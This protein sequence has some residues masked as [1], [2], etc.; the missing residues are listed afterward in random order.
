MTLRGTVGSLVESHRARATAPDHGNFIPKFRLPSWHAQWRGVR[1]DAQVAFPIAQALF[2]FARGSFAFAQI[3]FPFA[4]TLFPFA[5]TPNPFAQPLFPFAQVFNPFA[6]TSNPFAQ[7]LFPFAQA[8]NPF[9][10]GAF[11]ISKT[12]FSRHLWR[13]FELY[14]RIATWDSGI[15]FDDPNLRWGSPPI[16]L[17]RAI[18]AMFRLLRQLQRQPKL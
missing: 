6:Q 14:K 9:A 5:Q 7:G 12:L 8:S 10:Q 11:A 3:P 1:P 17:S 18:P 13:F 15:C 16:S 2:P 4:Q